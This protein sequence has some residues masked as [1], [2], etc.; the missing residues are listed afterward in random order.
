MGC[1]YHVAKHQ[2]RWNTASRGKAKKGWAP[3]CK[4]PRPPFPQNVWKNVTCPVMSMLFKNGD[5]V[6][7]GEGLVTKQETFEALLRVGI[8]ASVARQT[9]DANFQPS[10]RRINILKMNTISDTRRAKDSEGPIEHFRSTGM[11]DDTGPEN[12][13]EAEQKFKFQEKI[14][15]DDEETVYSHAHIDCVAIVWDREFTNVKSND[16]NEDLRTCNKFQSGP[17]DCPSQLHGALHFMH[18]EFGSPTGVNA[19]VSKNDFRGMWLDATYPPDFLARSPRSCANNRPDHHGCQQCLD[20][21]GSRAGDSVE[22]QRYCRCMLAT[23]LTH[24]ELLQVDAYVAND[25]PRDKR[26]EA[27]R[28]HRHSSSCDGVTS[29]VIKNKNKN[30]NENK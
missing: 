15:L 2:V 5:L 12:F 13:N 30:K 18:Q 25:C 22:A 19:L 29:D 14:C 28:C 1:S 4:N 26:A 16:V 8:S 27:V 10:G 23:N 21:V 20:D 7:D 17:H 6:P 3:I 11:R 9:T 24:Q